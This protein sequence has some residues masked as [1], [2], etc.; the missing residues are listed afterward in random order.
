M[1]GKLHLV[2]ADHGSYLVTLEGQEVFRGAEKPALARFKQ[3]RKEME[4]RFPA[5]DPSPEEKAQV[6]RNA[7]SESVL[8]HN[9]FGGRKK[10]TTARS[11]RTFGG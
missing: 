5:R 3:L 4:R 9:R 6:L 11:T 1:P 8:P 10:K 7:L 2:R